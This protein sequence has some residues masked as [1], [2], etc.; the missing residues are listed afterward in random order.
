MPKHIRRVIGQVEEQR[1]AFHRARL[2]EITSEESRG[3]Q[4]DT[5]GAEDNAEVVLV[6][7]MCA[8][9]H[10]L[11]LHETSLTTDLCGDFVVW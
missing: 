6:V 9:V 7:V 1:H 4:V 11:I 10:I 3:I 8:L 2:L 5:H